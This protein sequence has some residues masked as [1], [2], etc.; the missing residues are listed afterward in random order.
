MKTLF[1]C[2]KT[3]DFLE[4]V[5]WAKLYIYSTPHRFMILINPTLIRMIAA[6]DGGR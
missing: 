3:L 2:F 6:D 1:I 4:A 5:I